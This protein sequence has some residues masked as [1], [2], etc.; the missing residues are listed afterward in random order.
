MKRA[1]GKATA[2]WAQGYGFQFW[3]CRNNAFRGDGKDGQFCIVIPEKD[4]V[5]A[6]TALTGDMQ[7]E[8]NVVWDKLLPALQDGPLPEDAAAQEQLK[9]VVSKLEAHP[10][11]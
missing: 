2:D 6:I 8:L 3:R 1:S 10:K 11:K 7:K 5:V 9:T 4:T